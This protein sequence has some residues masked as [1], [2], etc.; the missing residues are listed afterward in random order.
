[1]RTYGR[2][3]PPAWLEQRQAEDE[4]T[5]DSTKPRKGGMVVVAS[6]GRGENRSGEMP[7][8]EVRGE[9]IHYNIKKMELNKFY[10]VELKGEPYLYRKISDHEVEIYGE[11]DVEGEAATNRGS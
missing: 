4:G 10:F 3:T 5:S 2:G 11:A 6:R 8:V 1:V 7:A 9:S